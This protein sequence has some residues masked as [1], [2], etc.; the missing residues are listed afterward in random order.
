MIQA[1]RSL[2]GEPATDK[3]LEYI[4]AGVVLCLSLYALTVLFKLFIRR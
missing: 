2:I 3:N 1:I 4:V